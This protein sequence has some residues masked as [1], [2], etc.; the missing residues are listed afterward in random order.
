[1]AES[2]NIISGNI[3][4]SDVSFILPLIK[5]G[6]GKWI[7]SG[8]NTYKGATTVKGGTLVVAAGGV[9]N[10]AN[11]DTGTGTVA[12]GTL[13]IDGGTAK[14]RTTANTSTALLA[15]DSANSGDITVTNN[16][17]LSISTGRLI[18][19][20]S[21]ATPS[22]TSVF[23]QDSGTTTVAGSLYTANYAPTELYISGGD[24]TGT[25]TPTISQ[26]ANTNFNISGT[27]NV[28]FPTMNLGGQAGTY[29]VN[30]NL[31]G[32]TLAV[33]KIANSANGNTAVNF[34]GGTLKARQ[35]EVAFLTADTATI[36]D[37][38][39]TIDT[40]EFNVTIGQALT[41]L[42]G[43]TTDSLT[44]LGIGTLT[45]T[46]TNT[47][48][49]DTNVNDGTLELASG[50]SQAFYPL[51]DGTSNKIT[52]TGIV[53]LDGAL[54]IDLTNA[55]TATS[56]LLVDVGNLDETYGT[57]F[58]VTGFTETAVDSGVWTLTV[59]TDLYTF[60][61]ASGL[62]T[63]GPAATDDY[64]TWANSFT[65]VVGAK[66]ADDDDDGLSNFDEYAFGLDPQSGASVNPISEQLSKTTGLFK[67]TR[68]ATPGT[69]GVTYSYE[70]STT[71]SGA[72]D[73][74]TPDSVVSDFGSP[75]EE[76]TVDIPNALLAEPKLFIRVKAVKP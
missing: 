47:Y 51:A 17:T 23:T 28:T 26:R 6:S 64:T 14:F 21:G 69:T 3:G 30:I 33:N 59:D 18:L 54:A 61:E 70:S 46:G 48:G 68:R 34:N 72:W 4:E 5:Q 39:G 76:I 10:N 24:F 9:I 52:G 37:D 62:L 29:D 16:G 13:L 65:P 20:G 1:M 67:Y 27:A 49:G 22:G 15:G 8:T 50:G 11:V 73:P 56:W 31:D 38:G 55:T 40:Q 45:L 75:I 66:T 19:G 63:R 2:D 57:N 53:T 44:K 7:L 43:A 32:G 36:G 60:T 25:G 12:G 74:F 35:D 58:I 42:D 71:L 41:R